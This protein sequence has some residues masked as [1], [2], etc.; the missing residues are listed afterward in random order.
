LPSGLDRGHKTP[1]RG[2]HTGRCIPMKRSWVPQI[3]RLYLQCH[4]AP[5]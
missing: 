2:D 5:R 1:P 4:S 3:D